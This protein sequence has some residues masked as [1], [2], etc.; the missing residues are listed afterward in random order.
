ME[1]KK[2]KR[3]VKRRPLEGLSK[4]YSGKKI[5]SGLE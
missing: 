1:K 2:Q 3:W 4:G 5:K